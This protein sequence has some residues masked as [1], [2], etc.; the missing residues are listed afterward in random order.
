MKLSVIT[1]LST[2]ATSAAFAPSLKAAP[3]ATQLDARKP[4]ISGNW[5]LNP[6]TKTEAVNLASEIAAKITADSPD[7][8]VALFVPY[9]FLEAAMGSVGDKLQI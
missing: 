9:V 5:K 8:E 2:L 4:F 7:A 1:L 6:Q 3:S